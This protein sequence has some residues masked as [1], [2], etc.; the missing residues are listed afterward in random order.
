MGMFAALNF[1]LGS[2]KLKAG[3]VFDGLD[4]MFKVGHVENINLDRF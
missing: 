3:L 4:I 2:S 1:N